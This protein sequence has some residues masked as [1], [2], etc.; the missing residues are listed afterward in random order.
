MAPGGARAPLI[1][2][3]GFLG[4]RLRD[5]E[6]HKVA[7]GTMANVLLGGDS[8]DL[9]LSLNGSPDGAPGESLVPYQIYESLW[10]V[11]YYREILRA[12]REA[13][14]Y[15]I[16]DIANPRPG[17]NAF[18]FIYDWR[19]DNVESARRL[20]EAIAR[21]KERRGDPSERFDVVAH[22]QGGLIARYYIR[23]GTRDVVVQG[24]P[25]EP[26][27]AGAPHVNKV[28]L[29]GTPNQGCLESLRILHRGIKK[30]FRPMRPEVVF[31]MPAVY[32]MLPPPGAAVFADA[33]GAPLA[34][35]LYDA[36]VWERLGWSVFSPE[37]QRRIARRLKEDAAALRAHNER[38]RA[39]LKE[40][41]RE[42]RGFHEALAAP[43]PAAGP[44]EPAVEYH[45]FGSDCLST[46]K[47]AIVTR[48]HGMPE[49]VFDEKTLYGPGDGTVLIGSLLG[50]S[51]DSTREP[52]AF[53][54]T[55]FVCGQHGVLPNNPV[56]QSSLLD[57]LLFRGRAMSGRTTR[58]TPVP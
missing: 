51:H 5:P 48:R 39:F 43:E 15:Q 8:D 13:G 24:G 38:L 16:G 41:L 1:L 36:A 46:L 56:F 55:S 54:S 45:A 9:A 57:L 31:T 25:F 50:I 34:L 28:I 23:Y 37:T 30:V 3:H 42:A 33:S 49:L 4:S 20:G 6:T 58:T 14:G 12:L 32:Q 47:T 17:D 40:R 19:R 11:D 18:V 21:L 10:G 22:S 35:D 7:W 44:G 52:L 27:M 29:V 53:S 26:T 2:I